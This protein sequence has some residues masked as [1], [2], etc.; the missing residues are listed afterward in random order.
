[1]GEIRHQNEALSLQMIIAMLKEVEN[2][3]LMLPEPTLKGELEEFVCA[4]LIS[5]GAALRGE[6]ISLVS[7][8]GMLSTWM[9]CTPPTLTF[10]S[11]SPSMEGL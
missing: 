1:M 8:K 7:L 3:W 6:G 4:L 9:E 2:V 11:W 10:T 5:F